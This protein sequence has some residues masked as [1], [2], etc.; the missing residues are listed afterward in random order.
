[1]DIQEHSLFPR[2]GKI[3]YGGEY[4]PEQWPES[5]W[6]QDIQLM[7]LANVNMVAV[8]VFA[9]ASIESAPGVY[10]FGWLD[11]VLELLHGAG[12][13]VALGT[14]TASP[15][16]WF[17]SRYP[18]C[19]PTTSDG[20]ILG[21]GARESYCP[22]A[23]EYR[24]AA[25]SIAKVI[26]ARYRDHPALAMWHVNNGLGAHVGPCHCER[27]AEAFRDWLR[28]RYSDLN[29]LNA[30]WGTAFWGQRYGDWTEIQP[31]RQAPLPV[32]PTQRLDF[33]RFSS[34]EY[35]ACYTQERDVLRSLRPDIPATTNFMAGLAKGT[36]YWRWAQEVDLIANGHYLIAEDSRSEVDL[37]LSADLARSLA[38]GRPWLLIEHSTGAVNW[39]PRNLAKIP[40]QMRRNSMAHVARGADGAM[41]FQWRAARFGSEK[42]HS[43]MVPHGGTSTQIW[44]DVVALGAD[45]SSL[46]EVHGSRVIADV[47]VMW[48]WQSWW[49]MEFD[50]MPTREH[51]YLDRIRAFYEALWDRNVTVDFV[52]PAGDLSRY[53]A[54]LVPS[55]YLIGQSA[56]DNLQRYVDGGGVL[57]VSYFSGI[58]DEHDHVYPGPFPG[59]LRNVLGLTVEE[60]H[61]L[62]LHQKVVLADGTCGDVWSERVVPAGAETVV[63]FEDGPDAGHPALTRYASGAGVAWY[64]ATR[65][66]APSLAPLIDRLLED[67][68]ISP[69][70]FPAGVEVV[71][72][73]GPDTDYLF[74]I[75]HGDSP[76]E[77][78]VTGVNLLDFRRYDN[79]LE[80]PASDVVVLRLDNRSCADRATPSHSR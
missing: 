10:D 28:S 54:V 1:M 20:R 38:G 9:W 19:R 32:N 29:A 33:M 37:A 16:P 4:Y 64:L 69:P 76:A 34:D 5:I 48:D 51:T 42:F 56:A 61:P 66:D 73:T 63:R 30:A 17:F 72:R 45:L 75:N 14:P 24:S 53:R 8:G 49:A 65:L 2:L 18:H 31:P 70:M 50:D 26:A 27:S 62:R 23:P 47:A 55:L 11:K 39:Q 3:I 78:E 35:L 80:I 68:A 7:R 15:P 41:F 77:V 58:V 13:Q 59:A 6:V 40:G 60:L 36:D 43:A 67:A 46:R 22:S 44:R 71:R 12:I 74:L 57:L 79:D 25:A 52:A 21:I